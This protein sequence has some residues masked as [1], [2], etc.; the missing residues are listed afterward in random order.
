MPPAE[1][2]AARIRLRHMRVAMPAG[3]I[4]AAGAVAAAGPDTKAAGPDFEAARPNFEAAGPD[5]EAGPGAHVAPFGARICPISQGSH[6]SGG[7][8]PSQTGFKG[9][10]ITY[11]KL[12]P[13]HAI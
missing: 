6:A 1:G 12:W 3:A 13:K 5:F 9:T 4:L 7:I 10:P 2:M 8:N 11:Y